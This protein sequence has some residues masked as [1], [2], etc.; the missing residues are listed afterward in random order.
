MHKDNDDN[1]DNATGNAEGEDTDLEGILCIAVF[2][3]GSLPPSCTLLDAV[4][5]ATPCHTPSCGDGGW[6]GM[7]RCGGK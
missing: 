4:P 2:R 5:P 3:G 1:K 7:T 6:E